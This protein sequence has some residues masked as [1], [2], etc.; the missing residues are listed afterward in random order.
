M[1]VD[2]VQLRYASQLIRPF[3][4]VTENKQP[5]FVMLMSTR[6]VLFS[7]HVTP[8]GPPPHTQD[9]LCERNQTVHHYTSARVSCITMA[10]SI[11]QRRLAFKDSALNV[12]RALATLYPIQTDITT[13]TESATTPQWCLAKRTLCATS[14]S[15]AASDTILRNTLV[16]LLRRDDRGGSF[17]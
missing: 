12:A 8:L 15:L 7:F 1:Y 9:F 14:T 16:P 3:T 10:T 4:C 2:I 13:Q 6:N 11:E 5:S 17:R